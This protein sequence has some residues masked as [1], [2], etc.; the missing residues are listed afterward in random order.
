MGKA[1]RKALA[2][3]EEVITLDTFGGRIYVEWDPAAAVTPLGQLPFLVEFLNVS[4]LF[5]GWVADCPLSYQSNNGSDKRAVLATF[6]LSIL[7]GHPRYA[8]IS[9]IRQDGI[10]PELLGV[11]KLVIRR[12]GATC[13]AA[14]GRILRCFLARPAPG[15]DHPALAVHAVDTGFRCDGGRS[16]ASRQRLLRCPSFAARW[17]CAGVDLPP[18]MAVAC[19]SRHLHIPVQ[20]SACTASKKVR[21]S[22][23]AWWLPLQ[24]LYNHGLPLAGTAR[25]SRSDRRTVTT[26]R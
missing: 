23:S 9:A 10:H 26:A 17:L 19:A 25:R 6:L 13:A 20:R 3:E 24:R 2:S 16:R 7:A 1:K 22:G 14:H 21:S 4:G 11:G 8:H 18:S 12:C 15:E 5:E